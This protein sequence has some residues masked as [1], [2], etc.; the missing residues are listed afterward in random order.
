MEQLLAV[1]LEITGK[2]LALDQ[3]R[4]PVPV[5]GPHFVVGDGVERGPE[6]NGFVSFVRFALEIQR[7]ED[8]AM[9][10]V[11]VAELEMQFAMLDRAK[12][13]DPELFFGFAQ[14]GLQ[15]RFAGIDLAARAID[16]ARAKAAFLADEENF[17]VTH[18][19]EKVGADAWLPS[20]PVGQGAQSLILSAT[21][22]MGLMEME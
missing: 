1:E 7:P 11:T 21:R 4:E 13:P 9:E 5:V 8:R 14:G 17:F 18:D 16:L 10:A 3:E 12:R 20:R 22:E 2:M 15:R 6:R 19:E